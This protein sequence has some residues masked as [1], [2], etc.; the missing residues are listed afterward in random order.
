ME[1]K[2]TTAISQ[3]KK[4]PVTPGIF[5]FTHGQIFAFSIHTYT[6]V[7]GKSFCKS[8]TK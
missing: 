8:G 6:A 3:N 2:N 5:Y 4:S 7:L 1:S